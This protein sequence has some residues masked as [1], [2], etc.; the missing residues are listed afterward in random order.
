MRG[1]VVA[2]HLVGEDGIFLQTLH[3]L[4]SQLGVST[5]GHHDSS[6]RLGIDG[7]ALDV[8]LQQDIEIVV[9]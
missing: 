4:L 1:I 8:L 2:A 3:I 5:F 7:L 6:H 9:G